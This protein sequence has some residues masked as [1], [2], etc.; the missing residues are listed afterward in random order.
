MIQSELVAVTA[1]IGTVSGC[2]LDSGV[3]LIYL[4]FGSR[5]VGWNCHR[6]AML[7]YS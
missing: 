1:D 3:I 5:G 4:F 2:R 6:N 7:V